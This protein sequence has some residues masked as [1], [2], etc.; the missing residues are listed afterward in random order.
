MKKLIALV[1][2][3]MTLVSLFAMPALAGGDELNRAFGF[4][5][6]CVSETGGYGYSDEYHPKKGTE[7][8]SEVRYAV[9]GNGSTAGFTNYVGMH[10]EGTTA[11]LGAN[12]KASN[13]IYYKCTSASYVQNANYAPGG[14]GN[15]KYKDSLGMT[16]VDINGQFRPH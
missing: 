2:T 9:T 11:L 13:M 6:Q 5:A 8:F 3:V 16:M 14:R 12:F 4:H 15:T 7:N 1:L 10:R